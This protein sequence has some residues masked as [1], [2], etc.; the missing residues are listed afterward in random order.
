MTHRETPGLMGIPS[1]QRREGGAGGSQASGHALA[2]ACSGRS[3][4]LAHR[5]SRF[6]SFH[7]KP[8]RGARWVPLLSQRPPSAPHPSPTGGAPRGEGGRHHEG[9]EGVCKTGGVGNAAARPPRAQPSPPLATPSTSN[10]M[11]CSERPI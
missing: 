6:P 11:V 2:Q 1:R 9:V 8:K 5:P 10:R 7:P 4:Q 3:R